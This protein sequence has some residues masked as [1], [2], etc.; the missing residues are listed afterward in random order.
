MTIT[1]APPETPA[2]RIM[3]RAA[4]TVGGEAALANSLKV[5]P[6]VLAAW[7]S[8]AAQPTNGAFLLALDIVA[9]GQFGR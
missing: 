9:K 8:G 2:S 7:L 5:A 3:R 1:P 4:E 6:E